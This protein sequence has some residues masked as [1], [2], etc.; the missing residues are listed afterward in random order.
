M[1]FDYGEVIFEKRSENS[2]FFTELRII[3]RDFEGTKL[4][5]HAAMYVI[6]KNSDNNNERKFVG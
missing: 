5:R 1:C 3:F 2:G 4:F 6:R